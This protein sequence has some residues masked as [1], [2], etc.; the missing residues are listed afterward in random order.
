MRYRSFTNCD[1]DPMSRVC[2]IVR[3]STSLKPDNRQDI[4]LVLLSANYRKFS[5]SIISNVAANQ[6]HICSLC[7]LK[8]KSKRS[9]P[10]KR[11]TLIRTRMDEN[12]ESFT[13]VL[14][15]G[16]FLMTLTGHQILEDLGCAL[17]IFIESTNSP[18]TLVI[19][20]NNPLSTRKWSTEAREAQSEFSL[21]NL[22][23]SD[24]T[25]R[26]FTSTLLPSLTFSR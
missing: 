21:Q 9:I 16:S 15:K 7:F 12:G 14:T 2:E 10:N 1:A 22:S 17:I 6:V 3:I 19:T 18:A 13:S 8:S 26:F 25:K 5:G 11:R 20:S 23:Q 4:A 24:F